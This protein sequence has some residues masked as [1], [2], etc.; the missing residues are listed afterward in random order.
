MEEDKGISLSE[1][2]I[3]AL[4]FSSGLDCTS[5]GDEHLVI[6]ECVPEIQMSKSDSSKQTHHTTEYQIHTTERS[7]VNGHK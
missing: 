7:P 1:L 2:V 4:L 3:F 6:H 5:N